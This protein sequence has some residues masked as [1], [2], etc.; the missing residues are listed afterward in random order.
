MTLFELGR[1]GIET[2][3]DEWIVG[4]D[5]ETRRGILK[6]RLLD[7][8]TYEQLAEEFGKSPRRIQDI[9]HEGEKI[10]YRHISG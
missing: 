10:L 7:G 6:R 3:V 8:R 2:L 1:T 9:V 5:A 4:Y